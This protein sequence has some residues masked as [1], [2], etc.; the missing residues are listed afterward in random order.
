MAY[1]QLA[2]L[3]IAEDLHDF[4][5]YEA[6]SGTGVS[7]QQFWTGLARLIN[8]FKPRIREHL[9][10][11]GHLQNEIDQYHRAH[12]G[13]KLDA[14]QFEAL[15]R[16]IGYLVEEPEDFTIR[17]ENADDAIARVAGPQFIVPASNARFAIK[18]VNGR[19]GSLYD[20]L[21]GTDVIDENDGAARGQAYNKVRG[22]RVIERGRAFL[23]DAVPLATGS[24]KSATAYSVTSGTL[25]VLFEGGDRTGLRDPGQ[26]TGYQGRL[27]RPSSILLRNHGL[28]IEIEIDR[29]N[30]IGRDDPAGIADIIL[31]SAP[32]AIIDFE[33]NVVAIDA[34]DKIGLY[35]NWLELLKGSLRTQFKKNSRVTDRL[36]ATDRRYV[37][38]NGDALTLSGRSLMLVRPA[39]LHMVTDAVLDAKVEAIPDT[40][41]DT[42]IAAL[43]AI[44]DRKRTKAPR[45][46]ET[47]SIYIVMP[48]LHGPAEVA[49]AGELLAHIEDLLRLPRYTLK[50]GLMNEEKRT[51]LNLKACIQA[52]ADRLFSINSGSFDRVASEIHTSMERGPMLR[53]SDMKASAWFT[54][55]EAA[56]IEQGLACGLPGRAQIGRGM[57]TAPDK[58]ADMLA[59]KIADPLAGAT[60][61]SVPTPTAATLHA[62][63][64]HKVDVARC[65]QELA[66]RSPTGLA[67]LIAIPVNQTQIAL[68]DAAQELDSHC[69]AILRG[70]ARFV[71]QGIGWSKVLDVSGAGVMENRAALRLSSQHIA[72][73]LHH[74]IVTESEI[75]Q[76]LRRMAELVD[77]QNHDDPDYRPLAPNFDGPAFNASVDLI[78]KGRLEENFYPDKILHLARREAKAQQN[79]VAAGRFESL[80]GATARLESGEAYRIND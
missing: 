19:W 62:L 16:S 35:R 55:G 22:A 29:R 70:V 2:G 18:A 74:G 32:T 43:I 14:A 45:N 61:A 39:G 73:W 48:K 54:A 4:I 53:A 24:H 26:F 3:S 33:D 71:D 20:A 46:T 66:T 13:E 30:A 10:L 52:A 44:P 80:K 42:V 59:E 51:S 40:I 38:P 1:L 58:M 27:E 41:L 28:H 17:T 25:S 78:F 57:W 69:H 63:H 37:A 56:H 47:G 12:A 23:D 8:D 15:L 64:Y 11:R 31:E 77:R 9:L 72:N 75:T 76:S 6:L 7:A 67:D 65:Q 49:L 50:M 34:R 21:Y 79:I 68:A 5:N 60:T 36:L